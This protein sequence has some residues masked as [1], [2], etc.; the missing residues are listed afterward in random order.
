MN[1]QQRSVV[2][3]VIGYG[4]SGVTYQDAL[5]IFWGYRFVLFLTQ[6]YTEL[7]Q[8]F[9]WKVKARLP[10]QRKEHLSDCDCHNDHCTLTKPLLLDCYI[11]RLLTNKAR[12]ILYVNANRK[13]RLTIQFCICSTVMQEFSIVRCEFVKS[14]F[15]WRSHH[16]Y[17][18]YG[19]YL[20]YK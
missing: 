10:L 5:C 3:Q 15:A 1:F 16:E 18:A 20:T 12:F 11:R 4:C 14:N 6:K 9:D 13:Q 7:E 2:V 19:E 17:R 8:F